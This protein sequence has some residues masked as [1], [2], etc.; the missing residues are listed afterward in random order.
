MRTSNASKNDNIACGKTEVF[1]ASAMYKSA[2]TTDL[3]GSSALESEPPFL[4]LLAGVPSE[5]HKGKSRRRTGERC[6]HRSLLGMDM[7]RMIMHKIEL[8]NDQSGVWDGKYGKP[9]IVQ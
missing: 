2:P 3:L 8:A 5:Q 6:R 9:I 1:G 7:A 4:G